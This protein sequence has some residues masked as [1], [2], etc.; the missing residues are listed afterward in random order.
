MY[1]GA[2]IYSPLHRH[3]SHSTFRVCCTSR[4]F[5][6]FP[7][8]SS[9]HRRTHTLDSSPTHTQSRLPSAAHNDHHVLSADLTAL[10]L[11]PSTQC[12]CV[13]CRAFRRIQ[14]CK[15][16]FDRPSKYSVSGT[17]PTHRLCTR[18]LARPLSRIVISFLLQLGTSPS[19]PPLS[20][21]I[22]RLVLVHL[23][24]S[25]PIETPIA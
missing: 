6:L 8:T 9:P 19:L 24:R 7:P 20:R 23:R 17:I 15:P 14:P 12:S 16:E 1:A 22:L 25:A 3:C 11:V 2:R 10:V 13:L 4:W 21:L 5:P 18:D